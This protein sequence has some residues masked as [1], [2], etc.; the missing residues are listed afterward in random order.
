MPKTGVEPPPGKKKISAPLDKFLNTPLLI[1]QCYLELLCSPPLE[2]PSYGPEKIDFSLTFVFPVLYFYV[3]LWVALYHKMS[4]FN[5]SYC[6]KY[7]S[8][9]GPTV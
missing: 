7:P 1:F 8:L 3:V 5:G 6:V 4:E 9:M 2:I